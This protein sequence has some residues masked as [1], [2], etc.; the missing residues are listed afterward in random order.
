[1][2][3]SGSGPRSAS[4]SFGR[5]APAASADRVIDIAA[6]DTLRFVPDQLTVRAG[7]TVTLRLTNNGQMTHELVLGTEADQAAHER[8][9]RNMPPG[10]PMHAANELS[11][12]PGST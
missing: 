4:W 11:V 12:A 6:L 1:S 10:A 2:C 5:P 7:E 9:M 8:E 3:S